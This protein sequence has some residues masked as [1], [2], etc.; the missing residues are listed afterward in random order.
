MRN[1]PHRHPILPWVVDFTSSTDGYR[2]LTKTKY[3]LAKGDHQLIEAY[4]FQHP[5]HHI[6]ELLTDICYMTYK[7]RIESKEMLCRYVRPQYVPEEYPSSVQ[8][9]YNWSPDECIPEFFEDSK[10][11]KSIHRDLPDLQLPEWTKT[12]EEFIRW[13]KDQLESEHVSA[14][15]HHWID[16]IYG[17]KVS[18]FKHCNFC[19]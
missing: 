3:R 4:K 5:A 2:D 11:F 1:D 12:S 8:R 16:L 7:A 18:L 17:Y 15:L 10:L 6:P 14:N 9:L 19:N 13:H